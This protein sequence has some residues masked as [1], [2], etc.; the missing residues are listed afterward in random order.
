ME[1][2]EPTLIAQGTSLINLLRQLGGASGVSATGVF[3]AWRLEV[4]GSPTSVRAFH[5]AFILLAAMTAIAALAAR[6]MRHVSQ[7]RRQN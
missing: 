7:R 1:G 3:L 5:E 4:A 6:G 2:V